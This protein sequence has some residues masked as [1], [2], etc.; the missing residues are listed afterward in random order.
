MVYRL[1]VFGFIEPRKNCEAVIR[2][3]GNNPEYLLTISG[4]GRGKRSSLIKNL[5]K[6]SSNFNNVIFNNSF[7]EKDDVFPN[8]DIVV[9]PY[10]YAF[11]FSGVI[12]DSVRYCKPFLVSD[13]PIFRDLFSIYH[14]K[15]ECPLTPT[16]IAK[17]LDLITREY[18]RAKLETHNLAQVM[19]WRNV[20]EKTIDVYEE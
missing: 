8:T 5:E 18:A 6:L 13:L 15:I 10:E 11:G 20:A 7:A 2:A 1:L 16:N 19:S 3:V 9:M 12:A 14:Y 17:A 4:T